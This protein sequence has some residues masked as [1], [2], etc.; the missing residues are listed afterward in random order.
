MNF[1]PHFAQQEPPQGDIYDIVVLAPKESI[2]PLLTW[3]GVLILLGLVI[4]LLLRRL[5]RKPAIEEMAPEKRAASRLRELTRLQDSLDGAPFAKSL[6]E[7]LKD[8]LS[9]KFDDPIRYETADEFLQRIHSG[10][11]GLPEAS[12]RDLAQFLSSTEKIKF[13]NQTQPA[14]ELDPLLD[15]AKRVIANANHPTP[16]G[17]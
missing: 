3:I 9:E 1:R 11:S 12:Q 13:A 5:F 7:L 4:F 10:T 17:S 16:K 14:S 2:G 15:L 6:S 8:Y